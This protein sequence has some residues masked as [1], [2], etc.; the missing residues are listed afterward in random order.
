MLALTGCAEEKHTQAF[1]AM[2]TYM[3]MDAWGENAETAL[4]RAGERVEEIEREISV[5]DA[6]SD[7]S[8]LN[9]AG[10]EPVRVR[11]DT[12]EIL[13]TAGEVSEASGGA[14]SLTLLPAARAWGFSGGGEYRIPSPAELSDLRAKVDD[15]KITVSGDFVTIPEGFGLD[16]GAVG[17]GFASDAALEVLKDEGVQSA[18]LNLGGNVR[19]LGQKDGGG[20]WEVAVK[21]PF[22]PSRTLGIL[23]VGECAVV[24]SGNYERYFE[25]EDGQIYGHILDPKTCAPARSGLASVTAVAENGLL[26]DA[27]ST[28]LFVLG[29]DG[30]LEYA[31]QNGGFEMLLVTDAGE[32]LLTPGLV[33]ENRSELPVK[34]VKP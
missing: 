4:S 33:F 15:S 28:A 30:A 23:S 6:G 8:A 11:A 25:G 17:K 32:I 3:T 21:N 20:A 14:L 22:E 1:F 31:R 2:D 34:V 18:V 27:L 7:L 24:T 19:T 12:L 10:G 29:E 5:T 16:F 13:K 9:G 26:A